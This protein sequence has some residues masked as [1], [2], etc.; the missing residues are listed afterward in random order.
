MLAARLGEF[1][2]RL[3]FAAIPADVVDA[4]KLR[5]LDTIGAGLAGV[6][7]GNHVRLL[8]LLESKG[9]AGVWGETLTLSA[10]EAALVNAFA[11]HS[12]YLE[13]GSRFTGGHPSS[14]VIPAVIADAQVRHASGRDVIAAIVAGYEVFLRLGRAIY[15]A[16]VNRGFQST[17][18]LGAVSSA[19]AIARL[20]GLAPDAAANAIAI[21][22]NL[23]SGHKE[24]LKA[25][26]S[27]PIQVARSC[28]GGI[29][30]ATLAGAGEAGA[31]L[32]LEKGFLPGFGAAVDAAGIVA[33]LGSDY[34]I[35]ETYLKRHAGCRGNH[36]P[37]DATLEL[38]A[39]EKIR[40]S[41]VARVRVAVDSV[42]RA[43]AIEPPAN[44]EQAQFSIAFSVALAFVEGNGSIFHYTN[45]KLADEG[46]HAMM[47]RIE[48]GVDQALDTNYPD[49][50]GS[51]VEVTMADGRVLRHTVPNARGEPE[52]PL[53]ARDVEEKFAALAAPRLGERASEVRDAIRELDEMKDAQE[54][55]RLLVPE[56]R[57]NVAAR[58]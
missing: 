34:R 51:T 4:V 53:T 41:D 36:A 27:Q 29:V 32:I 19:A 26:G 6:E 24:A 8:A 35:A 39:R 18:V 40:A 3:D 46:V 56:K 58:V 49:E 23:G 48:V 45:A 7:L 47:E 43:A 9:T 15:P 54:L 12:T 33:G 44:G 31:P 1:C 42:T 5:V 55:A 28:E 57:R 11:V 50:R 21:G 25:S 10:R 30:A 14:V 17:A 38:I 2:A 37:L 52:W 20:R 16:C 13:D 22:A